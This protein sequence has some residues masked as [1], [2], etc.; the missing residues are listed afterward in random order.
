MSKHVS[1]WREGSSAEW[2]GPFGSF[3]YEPNKVY[4]YLLCFILHTCT[5]TIAAQLYAHTHTHTYTHT[6]THT[7]IH[8]YTHTHTHTQTIATLLLS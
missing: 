2:R 7:H 8:T 3:S 6:H 1:Q 4:M 5:P